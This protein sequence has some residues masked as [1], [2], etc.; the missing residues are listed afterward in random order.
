MVM[1]K[2]YVLIIMFN[3]GNIDISTDSVHVGFKD[4]YLFRRE[5][6]QLHHIERLYRLNAVPVA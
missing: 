1:Y 2:F 5:L 4:M 3:L 6:L